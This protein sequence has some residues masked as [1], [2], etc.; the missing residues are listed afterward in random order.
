MEFSDF[1]KLI[2]SKKGTILTLVFIVVLFTIGL[3]LTSPLKYGAES[4][5]LVAQDT[6]G[7]DPYTISKSNEYLGNLFAQIVYSASFYDLVL[8]SPY[9]VDKNYFSGAYNKQL[10]AWQKTIDTK[11][12]SDTGIIEINIYHQNPYQAQQISLAVNDILINKNAYY[13]GNNQTTK[14][15]IIDQPLVSS[16]PVKP[17]LIQNLILAFVAGLLLSLF[18]IYLFPERRYDLKLWS[19]KKKSPVKSLGGAI[20]LEDYTGDR[21]AEQKENENADGSNWPEGDINNILRQ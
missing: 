6:A 16:Y 19:I 9:N 21:N 4:R 13:H 18:Y 11:T 10:K 3:S 14:I 7:N 20:K 8:E 5:L 12:I 2:K 1:L 17:N 15:N